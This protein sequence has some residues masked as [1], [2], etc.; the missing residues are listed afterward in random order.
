M[1]LSDA[2]LIERAIRHCKPKHYDSVPRWSVVGNL[3]GLGSTS[4]YLLCKRFDIDPDEILTTKACDVC[5]LYDS[6]HCYD[7]EHDG[8]DDNG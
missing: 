3:F 2:E 4:S 8:G 5:P 6:E 7:C 1:N